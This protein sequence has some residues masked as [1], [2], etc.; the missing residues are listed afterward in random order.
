[1]TLAVAPAS[2]GVWLAGDLHV[3]T[4]YS[5]DSYGGPGDDNTGLDDAN[6]YGLSVGEEFMLASTRGLDY[7][8]IT[9]HND[10]RAQSDP[11]FGTQGVIGV[12]GY[13]NSLKTHAQMLGATR[14]YE[15]GDKGLEATRAVADS[16]RRDGGVFQVNHPS[17]PDWAFR[18][19]IPAETS[20][21]WN[22]PW[23]YQPPFPAAADN[24][25]ALAFWQGWLDTGA[26]VA[27]VGGSDSHWAAT[28]SVQGVGQPTTWVYASEPTPAGVLAGLRAGRTFISHQPPAY[29]GPQIF[30]EADGDRDGA[31]EAMVGDTVAPSSPLR[32]RVLGG[33]G[34]FLRIVTDG[35]REAT[36]PVQVTSS[37][38]EHGF[39]VPPAAT[40][41]HAQLYGE[42]Q[43][44]GRQAGCAAIPS[45]DL[46]GS[47]TYCTNRVVMLGLT[48]AIFLRAP[49]PVDPGSLAA[50]PVDPAIGVRVKA[51]R[52]A[53]DSLRGRNIRL[54]IRGKKGLP[55]ISHFVLQYR[56]TGR[57]TKKTYTTLR[58]RLAKRATRVR[59]KKGEI[60]ETYL[61]RITAIGSDGKRSP[62][63]HS[64]TVF[65]YDDRGKGRR[66][67]RGWRRIKNRRAWL[68]GY[69]QTSR[70]GATLDFSTRGG[71][72]IYLIARTGPD[73]GKA[74]FGR[75]SKKRV[76]SFRT[77][78][79]RNRRV[80][81]TV[82]RTDK[83]I[84]RFRLKV[85][86]G[87]VTLDGFGVRRR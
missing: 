74:V 87:T 31:Y 76:V 38:F 24:D 55:A 70:R 46:S 12:P 15:N 54:R 13:E 43:P 32:V 16:L 11:G 71:G 86:S 48:S 17:S 82:N 65:P 18:Y 37:E 5:H 85:L 34:G 26:K 41:V 30:L 19:E 14:L 10:I 50:R 6:T 78:T 8:A 79:R 35:G 3:H 49:E 62:F 59:F 29:A 40:W 84:Y 58:A 28:A 61:F 80:V 75:G 44:T 66:Y 57:G 25:R 4:T 68:G 63:R 67:S 83:R 7:V 39:V 64:R 73:G 22:L 42:D 60:G 45:D 52:L 9:D 56:R 20:E 72:R 51:P 36:D 27:A 77:K 21:V 47:F 81:A 1:M 2:A 23:Y 53:S 69:S 33:S